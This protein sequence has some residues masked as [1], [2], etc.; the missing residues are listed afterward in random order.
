[1]FF[2]ATDSPINEVKE[3][4]PLANFQKFDPSNECLE[5]FAIN[6]ICRQGIKK[7]KNNS[8]Q[9][10]EEAHKKIIF[11]KL[12]AVINGIKKYMGLF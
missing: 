9:S 2:G 1:M 11:V 6:S 5:N 4:G 3:I 10:I 8:S 12:P 7:R